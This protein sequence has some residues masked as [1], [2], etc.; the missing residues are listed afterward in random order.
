M[1][2]MASLGE[3]KRAL[4]AMI[5]DARQR[6]NL[7]H[8]DVARALGVSQTMVSGWENSKKDL[9][10]KHVPALV[11]LMPSLPEPQLAFALAEIRAF[12]LQEEGRSKF[13]EA[14]E[15]VRAVRAQYGL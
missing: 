11:S 5:R 12:H 3:M 9:A 10:P 8:K 2:E 1:A 4:G 13:H 7:T 14:E 15:H 6:H